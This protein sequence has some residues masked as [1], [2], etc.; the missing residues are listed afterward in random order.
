M[1][2]AFCICMHIVPY[3]MEEET[4]SIQEQ[5]ELM[6]KINK[7]IPIRKKS[8]RQPRGSLAGNKGNFISFLKS[9]TGENNIAFIFN[10]VKCLFVTKDVYKMNTNIGRY[11]KNHLSDNEL[12]EICYNEQ[13]M[14]VPCCRLCNTKICRTCL[15]SLKIVED[16]KR[17]IFYKCPTCRTPHFARMLRFDDST[18]GVQVVSISADLLECFVRII[19]NNQNF[20]LNWE[21]FENGGIISDEANNS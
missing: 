10:E 1:T 12:C 15:I 14:T 11:I 18:V 20:I 6:R 2:L 5:I 21:K 4:I 17:K 7:E 3:K 13:Q 19:E 8:I 9:E 16:G